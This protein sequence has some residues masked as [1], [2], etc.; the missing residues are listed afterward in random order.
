MNKF[1]DERLNLERI[2]I[3]AKLFRYMFMCF[4]MMFAVKEFVLND[5]SQVEQNIDNFILLSTAFYGMFLLLRSKSDFYTPLKRRRIIIGSSSVGLV[6]MLKPLIEN[7][8]Q[9]GAEYLLMYLTTF[10]S[11]FVFCLIIY[12]LQAVVANFRHKRFE[13]SYDEE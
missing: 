13:D 12:L 5:Y 2:E 10:L 11:G 6:V 4:I 8:F 1:Q 7:Q 9:L 3:E